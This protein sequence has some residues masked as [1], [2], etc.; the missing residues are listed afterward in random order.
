MISGQ[1]VGNVFTNKENSGEGQEEQ[2][3]KELRRRF[4]NL[5][6]NFKKQQKRENL[7]WEKSLKDIEGLLE[8]VQGEGEGERLN[9][10]VDQI[11]DVLERE[12]GR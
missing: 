3:M 5:N 1:T 4:E 10:G 9:K 2:K 6:A 12:G 11:I 7:G 8:E